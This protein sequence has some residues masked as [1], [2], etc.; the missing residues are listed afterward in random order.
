[1]GFTKREL[2][3]FFDELTGLI[4]EEKQSEAKILIRR[5]ILDFEKSYKYDDAVMQKDVPYV[6]PYYISVM[7]QVFQEK[8]RQKLTERL[9]ELDGYSPEKVEQMMHFRIYD[10]K[11]LIDIEEYAKWADDEIYRDFAKKL[12]AS[13]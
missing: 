7:P 8:I 10:L 5:F 1:M 9:T 4:S 2:V 12:A 6:P 3:R 13:R 11:E